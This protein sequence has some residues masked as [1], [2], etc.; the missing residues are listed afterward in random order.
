MLMIEDD[1]AKIA[2]NA[3][4]EVEHVGYFSRAWVQYITACNDVAS[5]RKGRGDVVA[6]RLTDDADVWREMLVQCV[7]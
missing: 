4:V 3:I 1:A 7:A 2:V 6:A 5:K